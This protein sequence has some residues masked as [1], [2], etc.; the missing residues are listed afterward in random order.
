[1][2]LLKMKLLNQWFLLV[3]LCFVDHFVLKEGVTIFSVFYGFWLPFWYLTTGTTTLT[4]IYTVW[5]V[6]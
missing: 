1:M 3:A 5:R 2:F 6:E 4:V